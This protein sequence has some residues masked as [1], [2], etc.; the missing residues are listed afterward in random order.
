M[1]QAALID[2]KALLDVAELFHVTM[3]VSRSVSSRDRYWM[4]AHSLE[5]RVIFRQSIDV[6]VGFWGWFSVS[7]WFHLP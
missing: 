1:T 6:F 3:M 5:H 7:E 2:Q 4:I